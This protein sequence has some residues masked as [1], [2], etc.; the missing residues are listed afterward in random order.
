MPTRRTTTIPTT[1]HSHPHEHTH[2]HEHEHHHHEHGE[3]KPVE[4]LLALMKYMTGHNA[5]HTHE[6]E[7]LAHEVQH[8]GQD[9]AYDEIMEAVRLFT[10]GNA[11]LA[12]ALEKMQAEK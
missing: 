8:A 10:D 12:K 2:T 1:M 9:A 5:S 3:G 4:E 11:A 7:E 6:L